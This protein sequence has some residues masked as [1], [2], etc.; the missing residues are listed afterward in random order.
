MKKHY[1]LITVLLGVFSLISL[2]MHALQYWAMVAIKN[3]KEK[4][5][6]REYH[7]VV[8]STEN[9]VEYHRIFDDSYRFRHEAYNP[10]KLKYGYR[11]EDKKMYIYDFENQEKTLAFD[12]NL[13]IGNHF[14]T[15]NGMEW[16]VEGVKDTLVNISFCG[17]GVSVSK[18]LLSVKTLDGRV[19]D[20]WLEG[21]GSFSGHFMINSLD[22]VEYSQTLWMEYDMGEYLAREI[23]SGLILCHDSGWLDECCDESGN[24]PYTKCSFENGTLIFENVMWQ[25]EHR[26]YSCFYR[27]GDDIYQVWRWEFE[28]H[29][30]GESLALR[31][32]IMTFHGLPAPMSGRYTI[33]I[34]DNM[35][36]THIGKIGFVPCPHDS[37]YDLRGIR[38]HSQQKRGVIIKKRQKLVD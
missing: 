21:F 19:T 20:Q 32:D 3:G 38:V 26:D 15:F 34:D 30:D 33:H 31:K 12:F 25:W 24:E 16:M 5:T 10:V 28:P 14:T 23:N 6:I 9:G 2:E 29:A 37:L 13:S 27:D 11:W 35:Y 7:S 8:E 36:E 17:K 4:P 18:R 1:L 22:D